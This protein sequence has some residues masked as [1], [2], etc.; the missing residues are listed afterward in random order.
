MDIVYPMVTTGV[1]NFRSLKSMRQWIKRND[2]EGNLTCLGY[3][4]YCLVGEVWERFT[5]IGKKVV[6]LSE[7]LRI[8][9]ELEK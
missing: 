5:V 1:R 6:S 7:L 3:R 9:Q 8:A 2:P 4:E